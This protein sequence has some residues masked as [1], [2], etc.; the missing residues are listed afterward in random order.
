[1]GKFR[2]SKSKVELELE[3]KE[4]DEYI[5]FL[6]RQYRLIDALWFLG[7]EDKFGLDAAVELNEKVWEEMAGRSAREIKR[8]FRIDEKGL[9]GFIKALKYF[10][11]SIIVGYEIEDQAEDGKI[12][13]E[14]PHCPPQEARLKNGRKEFP[15]KEMH[16]REFKFFA[17]EIDG[18]IE[19][20]CI[21][22]PPDEHPRDLWCKWEFKLLE[23]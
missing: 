14:V 20:K 5:D 4:K 7:V 21:F 13:I 22:A 16:H 3:E 9:E 18:R 2:K 6:L 12:V 11:W 17:R 19:V 10:P 23:K 8:R 15:C 1:M